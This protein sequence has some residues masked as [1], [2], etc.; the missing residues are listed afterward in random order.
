M[1]GT[2]QRSL[3]RKSFALIICY[4][5]KTKTC[6]VQ[7]EK[8]LIYFC[9]LYHHIQMTEGREDGGGGGVRTRRQMIIQK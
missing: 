6:Q 2:K 4:D 7:V 3:N 5:Y 8:L 1:V 9:P